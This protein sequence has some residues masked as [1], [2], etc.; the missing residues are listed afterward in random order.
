MA[1]NDITDFN[2]C[3]KKFDTLLTS[4][5]YKSERYNGEVNYSL[6]NYPEKFIISYHTMVIHFHRSLFSLWEMM[7]FY[8]SRPGSYKPDY[9]FLTVC[10]EKVLQEYKQEIVKNKL[11]QIAHSEHKTLNSLIT[12]FL[13]K[14]IND[15]TIKQNIF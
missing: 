3:A 15:Y 10:A 12:H 8:A 2:K 4:L 5:G 6:G 11:K 9:E 14:A 7:D 1:V 13:V